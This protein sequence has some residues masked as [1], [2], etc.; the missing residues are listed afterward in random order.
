MNKK[1]YNVA[2]ACAKKYFK[3]CELVEILP[4]DTISKPESSKFLFSGSTSTDIVCSRTNKV[5]IRDNLQ[6][7][8]CNESSN[9][10]LVLYNVNSNTKMLSFV[11]M[12]EG[13][14]VPLTKDHIVPKMLGGRDTLKNLQSLC[15]TCNQ[16]KAHLQH[17]YD[18]NKKTIMISMDEYQR[19]ST[20]QSDFANARNIIKKS[21]K[22]VPWWM[23]LFGLHKYIEEKIKNPIKKM[24]YYGN[25]LEK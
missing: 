15:Y 3:D 20:K 2:S 18:C 12:V 7:K 22:R 19:L 25:N 14:M 13:E 17:D 1:M 21:I 11:I 16:E 23:K 6:C 5:V 24:G 8:S 4:A 10:A 9:Y